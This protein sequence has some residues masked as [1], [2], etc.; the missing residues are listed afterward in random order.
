MKKSEGKTISKLWEKL[1]ILNRFKRNE[2]LLKIIADL[3]QE[4]L[5]VQKEKAEKEQELR[6]HQEKEMQEATMSNL[7][8]DTI[9]NN[10]IF[11]LNQFQQG[12]TKK[13]ISLI[14][15]AKAKYKEKIEEAFQTFLDESVEME[16]N[17]ESIIISIKDKQRQNTEKSEK[18]K[19][20]TSSAKTILSKK[21]LVKKIKRKFVSIDLIQVKSVFSERI[22]FFKSDCVTS[23]LSGIKESTGAF[24]SELTGFVNIFTYNKVDNKIENLISDLSSKPPI[25][26]ELF[27]DNLLEVQE[28]FKQKI[29]NSYVKSGG[30]FASYHSVTG[31]FGVMLHVFLEDFSSLTEKDF[32]S[33]LKGVLKFSNDYRIAKLVLPLEEIL[34]KFYK[35]SKYTNFSTIS[36]K[37]KTLFTETSKLIKTVDTELER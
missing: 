4:I 22:D 17:N 30:I 32:L 26:D 29:E 15:S 8:N 11:Q 14:Q 1:T 34:G 37:I 16:Y 24:S 6:N 13:L 33:L 19:E 36:K 7:P 9:V 20:K 18:E 3:E 31:N 35:V 5:L 27:F 2:A 10:H 23:S 21:I 28:E 25:Q 12:Y